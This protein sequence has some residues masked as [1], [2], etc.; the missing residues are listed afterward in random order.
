ML[1]ELRLATALCV[2]VVHECCLVVAP[3]A[4]PADAPLFVEFASP[5]AKQGSITPAWADEQQ[6]AA[7]WRPLAE[8]RRALLAAALRAGG[9]AGEALPIAVLDDATCGLCMPTLNGYL[10][11]YPA[12]YAVHC[13]DGAL[14]ASRCLSSTTLRLHT[15][16]A[17]LRGAGADLRQTGAERSGDE[18]GVL[19]G[20]S[21]PS[22]LCG[23]AAWR[24]AGERWRRHMQRQHAAATRDGWPWQ[25]LRFE[26]TS[27]MRGV[28]L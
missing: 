2:A 13:L 5:S 21:V 15:A 19:L 28:A 14:A 22:E 8:V 9:G 27:C 18:Q 7:L 25:A 12:V 20:F 6:A 23:G 17:R 24:A 4:L 3:A 10:L 26:S 16:S 1:R 11:G